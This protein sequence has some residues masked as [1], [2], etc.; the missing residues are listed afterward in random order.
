MD[1]H[2]FFVVCAFT[3]GM[4]GVV[5]SIFFGDETLRVRAVL[6]KLQGDLL[7]RKLG[8]WKDL[9][10]GSRQFVVTGDNR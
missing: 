6:A 7:V 1:S 3:G 2:T 4:I 10:N 5:A 9:P 8:E